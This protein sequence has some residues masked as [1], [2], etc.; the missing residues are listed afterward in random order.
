MNYYNLEAEQSVL[1]SILINPDLAHETQLI[2][3]NF[4]NE[5]HQSIFK[6]MLELREQEKKID[7]VSLASK[8]GQEVQEIGGIK[9]LLELSQS[10]PTV[11]NFTT[12]ERIL[13]ECYVIRFGMQSIKDIYAKQYGDPKE[14]VAEVFRVAETL[15]DQA[16]TEVGFRHIAEGLKDHFEI[17]QDKKY[18]GVSVGTSTVGADLDKITG[19]WQNQTL[20]IVAARPSMGKTAYMLNNAVIN[21]KE[22]ETVAIFSLEMPE[23]QLFDRMIAAECHIDGE[24]I[25]TGQLLDDEWEKYAIGSSKLSELNIYIDD[26]SG[27]TIQEIKVAVRKLKKKHSDLIVYIDYLQ[28]IKGGRNFPSRNEEVGYVSSSLKQMSR[29]N[30]CP[31]I[32]LAQLSR[33]VEQRQDKRPMMSDLR[34]SGNIEQDADTVSFLYRDDYYNQ[35]SEKKNIIEIIVSK[36]RNGQVGTAEM[37]NMKSFGKFVNLE[38]HQY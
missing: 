20:N 35:D 16:H 30:T 38:R 6:H 26:R 17:L 5:Q 21:A 2:H 32:A 13:K 28:L 9:Y 34:E 27:L 4:H 7:I 22:G 19:K 25:R 8:M 1:G 37:V 33:S 23:Q 31:V 18:S 3:D 24:R 12:Y 15:G 14:F 11:A 29:E 10:V 36:N